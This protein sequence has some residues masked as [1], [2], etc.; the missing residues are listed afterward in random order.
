MANDIAARHDT[1][2][3]KIQNERA[4]EGFKIV[5]T[6]YNRL[7]AEIKLMTDSLDKIRL[8]GVNDYVSQSE[9]L[10]RAYAEAL[11]KGNQSGANAVKVQL[12]NLSKYGGIYMELSENLELF[13]KQRAEIK[14]KYDQVKIDAESNIPHKMV[15]N[16]AYASDKK[17]YPKRL[18]ITI[19]GGFATFCMC[20]FFII[21]IENWR[22]YKGTIKRIK[23]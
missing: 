8:L 9:V 3:N 4:T 22:R 13:L 23:N 15:V 12:D 1:I 5:E 6:E 16:Y 17:T 2:K 18:Y 19:G 21:G 20:I 14:V 10:N 7:N 11:A